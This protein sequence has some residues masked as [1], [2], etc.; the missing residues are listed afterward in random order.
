MGRDKALLKIGGRTLLEIAC[1]VLSEVF[2]DVVILSHRRDEYAFAGRPVIPDRVPDCGPLGGLHAALRHAAGRPV[3]L[4]AC[5]M[6]FVT[7]ELVR[8]LLAA[9]EPLDRLEPWAVFAR[10]GEEAQPLCG[11]YSGG[12]LQVVEERLMSGTL[13]VLDLV[14]GLRCFILEID[15]E[16]PFFTPRL[17]DNINRPEEGREAGLAI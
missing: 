17:L 7:P 9:A 4:L 12:C 2:D 6:P 8:Y 1:G 5:D 13:E 3:F 16:Q 15:D 14:A 10:S 11:L